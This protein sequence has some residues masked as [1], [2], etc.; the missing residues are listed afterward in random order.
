VLSQ[1]QT[2][3][4]NPFTSFDVSL[5]GIFAVFFL[6]A[7]FSL[8][9]VF[10]VRFALFCGVPQASLHRISNQSMNVKHFFLFFFKKLFPSYI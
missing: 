5:F 8:C 3:P 6:I 9:I 10:K 1:D 4:F 7:R 2:L